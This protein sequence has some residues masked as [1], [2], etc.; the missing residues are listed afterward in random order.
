[1]VGP[2]Y[3]AHHPALLGL[4]S[5]VT[6]WAQGLTQYP[7]TGIVDADDHLAAGRQRRQ[8]ME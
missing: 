6:V 5:L 4:Y 8:E 7:S 2:G 3:P 1:M